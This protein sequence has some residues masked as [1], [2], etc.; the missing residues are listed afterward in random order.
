MCLQQSNT[1]ISGVNLFKTL[2]F[3]KYSLNLEQFLV[4]PKIGHIINSADAVLPAFYW[5][6]R[7]Q[8]AQNQINLKF[9]Q[10]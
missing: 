1:S 2:T 9:M 4:E 10:K 3:P 7:H 6:V 8:I 5:H